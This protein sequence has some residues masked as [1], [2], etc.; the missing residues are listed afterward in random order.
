M[1]NDLG[2]PV[3][4]AGDYYFVSYISED[5]L[6]VS[7]FVKELHRRSVPLWYDNGIL[8]SR[9]W[10]KELR[11]KIKDCNGVIL[12]LTKRFFEKEDSYIHE[13]YRLA[14]EFKKP[15][16]TVILEQISEKDVP[17]KYHSLW[18][19]ITKRQC[20]EA[21]KF[22][23]IEAGVGKLLEGMGN[24]AVFSPTRTMTVS[25]FYANGIYVG[26]ML[27]GKRHGH[28]RM[29]YVDGS[30]FEGEYKDG[31][32]DGK[33]VYHFADGGVYEGNLTDGR[34]H[35]YGKMSYHDGRLY[36]GS[37]KDGERHGFGRMVYPNGHIEEGRWFKNKFIG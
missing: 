23:S 36:E 21:L 35:G 33:G 31:V 27:N 19:E 29:A 12:F 7:A 17:E 1:A 18:D 3:V 5:L 30:V 10:G 37:W 16:Y 32:K 28:G 8:P 25:M 26:G 2:V 22:R 11:E 4:I 34:C 13:E 15:V 24:T 20:V 9:D 14:T 6:R